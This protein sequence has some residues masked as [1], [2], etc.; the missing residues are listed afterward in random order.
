MAPKAQPFDELV[1][2]YLAQLRQSL[3]S[4][5]HRGLRASMNAWMEYTQATMEGLRQLRAS[6]SALQGNG[7]RKAWLSWVCVASDR[8]HR[9]M[10][11]RRVLMRSLYSA[12][13]DWR[14]IATGMQAQR[15][16]I[17]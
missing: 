9:Q 6:M 8:S 15:P 10:A 12:F 2:E 3:G 11:V 13:K 4:M 14:S 5:Q 1:A 7:L 16:G 17:R